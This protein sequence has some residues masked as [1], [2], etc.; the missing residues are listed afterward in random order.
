MTCRDENGKRSLIAS[1]PQ[2]NARLSS[3]LKSVIIYHGNQ[4]FYFEYNFNTMLHSVEAS[5]KFG[6]VSNCADTRLLRDINEREAGIIFS[7]ATKQ[8]DIDGLLLFTTCLL[9]Q[10]SR[11]STM[12]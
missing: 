5:S 10:S 4:Q 9:Y 6:F 2:K 12:A 1:M 7:K 8:R 11:M 3:L